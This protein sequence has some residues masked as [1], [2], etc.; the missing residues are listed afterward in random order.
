M[1]STSELQWVGTVECHYGGPA[2]VAET[3]DF[4]QWNGAQPYPLKQR[5]ILH[6]FGQFTPDL[7]A[8]YGRP[9]AGHIHREHPSFDALIED[10]D[11]LIDQIR[12]RFGDVAIEEDAKAGQIR[13]QLADGRSMTIALGPQSAYDEACDGPGIAWAHRLSTDDEAQGVFWEKEGPGAFS[14]GLSPA[15]DELV[16]LRGWAPDSQGVRQ[17][18][19]HV[20]R[21]APGVPTATLQVRDQGVVVAY[22]P[23]SWLEML[24]PD[25]LDR[26]LDDH[27]A[28]RVDLKETQHRI[29]SAFTSMAAA[30]DPVVML[31]A[32]RAPR[33]GAAVAMQP[34]TYAV[35]GGHAK[36]GPSISCIWCRFRRTP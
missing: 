6:Y 11:N 15:R 13:I 21:H 32:P 26:L 23:I 17:A 10:R 3:T 14:F 34:G 1:S 19:L 8:P 30:A 20:E 24:D 33:C 35:S 28:G 31:S 9:E 2:I 18:Q 5:R 22:A 27:D 4:T 12:S 25:T 16:L 7:P 36:L 29:R